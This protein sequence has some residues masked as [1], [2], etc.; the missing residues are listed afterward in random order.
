MIREKLKPWPRK[1]PDH[2]PWGRGR[3]EF[4]ETRGN[5]I[6]V[7]TGMA[8][9][10]RRESRCRQCTGKRLSRT[11][12]GFLHKGIGCRFCVTV[13]LPRDNV[14]ANKCEYPPFRYPLLNVPEYTNTCFKEGF[15][16]VGL[17][18]LKMALQKVLWRVFRRHLVVDLKATG[19]EEVLR[20]FRSA[21]APSSPNPRM[22]SMT[23]IK[24]GEHPGQLGRP[25]ARV[26]VG[27]RGVRGSWRYERQGQE[28]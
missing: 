22:S 18:I 17:L 24:V 23:R 12:W 4:G 28:I 6:C 14:L 25:V 16:E 2:G 7:A 27:H 9:R 19:S 11:I 1:G 10:C 5:D 21:S 20:V 8:V 15:W 26:L 3:S 13:Q